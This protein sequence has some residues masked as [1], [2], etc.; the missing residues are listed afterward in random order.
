M[1]YLALA[2]D[3]P[4]VALDTDDNPTLQAFIK[5]CERDVLSQ[6]H[7][8]LN[9]K[10]GF[11]TRFHA[12][13][14]VTGNIVP[15]FIANYVLSDYGSGAVFGCPAHDERDY[16]FAQKYNLDII[17]VIT[18]AVDTPT[19]L[20]YIEKTGT[21]VNS[22]QFDGLNI[23]DA[24]K[25][26]LEFFTEKNCGHEKI[27]YRLRD[28]GVSRQRYWGCP[29]PIVYCNDCGTVPVPPQDLPVKLPDNVDFSGQGNPL[30]NHATW[31]YVNCP[32]CQKNA[33]RETDT[34][35]TFLGAMIILTLKK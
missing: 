18:P 1:S 34:L 14:P 25:K 20:P 27:T 29:I 4:L 12:V 19:N 24:R 10:K 31:K 17:Q 5:Q 11:K 23:H 8:D 35:D 21:L 7:D 28:W 30:D 32:Q 2:Y 26:L 22:H 6:N 15:V 9:D 33:I 3:H 16:E 13:N